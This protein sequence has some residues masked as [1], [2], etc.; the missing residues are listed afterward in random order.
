M[1]QSSRLALVLLLVV[2]VAGSPVRAQDAEAEALNARVIELY[3]AGKYAEA[4]PLAER[5]AEAMNVAHGEAAPEYATA[6]NNLAELLKAT[7]RLAEAEPL[8]RRALAIDEA[9]LGADHPNVAIR[10]NNLALL[11]E[12]QG[13]W[14]EALSWHRRAEPILTAAAGQE[15]GDRKG[16]ARRDLSASTYPFRGHARAAYHVDR[17]D[18][19]LRDEGFRMAQWALQSDASAALAQM[20]LRLA[21]GDGALATKVRERQDLIGVRQATDKQ[22]LAAVGAGATDQTTALRA[23]LNRIDGR[24]DSLDTRI[25]REFPDFAVYAN[26]K[27][28]AIAEVRDLLTANEALVLLLDIPK[29]SQVPEESLIFVVTKDGDAWTRIEPGTEALSR[30]VAAL[31]CGLDRTAWRGDGATRCREALG[32][33]ATAAAPSSQQPLPFDLAR[34][35]ALYM[36]LFADVAPLIVGKDLLIVPAGPLQ[37]LP[38]HVLVSKPPE[39]TLAG[40][41]AL[42][43]AAWLI[44]DHAITVLPSVASLQALRCVKKTDGVCQQHK[45]GSTRSMIAFGN[46]ALDGKGDGIAA[47][48]R[49]KVARHRRDC[50]VPPSDEESLLRTASA[51][52]LG[53][54]DDEDATLGATGSVDD[55]R[56]WAPVPGT[57]WLLCDM[58]QDPAFAD[59]TVRLAGEATETVLRRMN[60]DNALASY[61]I[62]HFATHGVLAGQVPGIAEPGLILT[63]PAT[64]SPEDDGYLAASEVTELKLDADWVILSA[65]NTAAATGT[66]GEALSGLARAFFY[67][68]AR[69]LLVS[70]WEVNERAALQLVTAATRSGETGGRGRAEALRQAMLGL[71]ASS[72]DR[73]VHPSYWAPFVIV[74][75]GGAGR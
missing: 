46:P 10:L 30:E 35:H 47:S 43:R 29:F 28:Y 36:S 37:E 52:V 57:A 18:P 17:D 62:V 58:M 61:R 63:P 13:N 16:T 42:R 72:D 32:L 51:L 49:R 54:D 59:G 40:A 14:P 6:L 23:E 66:G 20:A 26:P 53:A 7:N 69:A 4:I 3:N 5:Y 64:A 73:A 34:A 48:L 74:G 75:E 25:A 12:N 39:P 9:S 71:I 21:A 67:A 19:R 2:I 33:A 11:A 8:M 27:P 22:L 38:F 44:R 31:R 60:T 1:A 55:I 65:C 41:A 15:A 45:R 56:K 70:H 24:L 50:V 68:G